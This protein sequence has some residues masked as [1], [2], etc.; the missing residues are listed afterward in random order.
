V[1]GGEMIIIH[2]ITRNFNKVTGFVNH[3]WTIPNE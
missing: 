3:R 1:G 2:E